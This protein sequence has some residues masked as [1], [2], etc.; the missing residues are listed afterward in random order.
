MKKL[1]I[2][3]LVIIIG[4]G[5]LFYFSKNS[6]KVSDELSLPPEEVVTLYMRATLGTI[7]GS[8]LDY[9]LAKTLLGG[10]LKTL[11]TDDKFVPFSYGIQNGPDDVKIDSVDISGES[12]K[13]TV[14]GYWGAEPSYRW[15][16]DLKVHENNWLI[17]NITPE[18]L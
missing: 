15:V 10:E 7:P 9:D 14:F 17:F 6:Q 13:V 12:A 8:L 11:F 3:F 4:G 5:A 18:P 1:S 16:F 2:L